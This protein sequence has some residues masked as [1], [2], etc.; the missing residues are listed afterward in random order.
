MT[1][2]HVF[3]EFIV[4][5]RPPEKALAI[6]RSAFLDTVGV[7]LAGAVEP[8]S[9][10]VQ[11]LAA[12][13]ASGECRIWGTPLKTSATWAALAN[14]AAAHA[15]DFDDMCF[16][17]LAH[18]SAP[19]VTTALAIGEQAATSGRAVLAAYVLGFEIEAV[20]GRTMN[21]RH[22]QQGWH[23]TST[24]GTVGAAA[25][26][27]HLLKLDAEA[28]THCLAIAASEASGLKENFGTMTKPLHA[29][30][31]ARNAVFAALLAQQGFTANEGALDGP[32]G[33]LA[34][35]ASEKPDLQTLSENLGKRWEILETGITVKLYPS[36][37]ATHPALDSVLDLRRE[38]N[39]L[40]NQIESVKVHVDS[41][42]P[43]LLAYDRPQ[44][45]LQGKFSMPFCLAA[46]LV[47]GEVGL[48]TFEESC[49]REARIQELLPRITMQADA[50]LGKDA[51][52]L[53][54]ATVKICLRDGR[55]L[56]RRADGAR[57]YPEHPA[58]AEELDNKFLSCGRRVLSE[59]RL[60]A[61][62]AHLRRMEA[63]SDVRQLTDS[64]SL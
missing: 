2:A 39:L 42:T 62:L 54:Q 63:L 59:E 46:A 34:A 3:A 27:A 5:A 38:H 60:Q 6:A 32:Q 37:S 28:T 31:G 61:A 48:A 29:G 52:G 18:P 11:K 19:L 23:C 8:G 40:A 45:G 55:T 20:L 56:H 14:G 24:L 35:M 22:Y 4:S 13:E 33:F 36:C 16:V 25:A 44:T 1:A 10:I 21:P 15:L 51:P 12:S 7:A 9:R 50:S 58:S 43:A 26:A 30:L 17:S 57:G 49:I 47:Y 64:I 41:L 53:T